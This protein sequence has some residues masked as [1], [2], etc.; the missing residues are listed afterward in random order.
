MKPLP[1]YRVTQQLVENPIK[2]VAAEVRRQLDTL[3]APPQGEVAI[4]VGSRGIDN[5]ALV[6]KTAGDWLRERGASPF[7]VP[8]MGSHNGA[9]AAGQRAMVESLGVTEAACGMPIRSSMEC[10]QVGEVDAGP[11]WMDRHAFQSAGVLALNRVKLHT[12]FSGPLQSGLVKMLVVGLG[13]IQSARVFHETP[14]GQMSASLAAMARPLLAT[15]KV[16]AGLALV[17][18]GA[19]H[20][21]EVHALAADQILAREP[22]LLDRCRHY[23]PRLPV[24]TLNVLVVES[25]G[26]TYSGTGMDPNVVG[27]RGP[28]GQADTQGTEV[29]TI[30]ALQLAEASQGNATGVGLADVVTQR[31]RDAIDNEKTLL[32]VLTTGSFDRGKA[33]VSLPDDQTLVA[34]LRDRFG[35]ARWMFIPNTLH[36]GVLWTTADVAQELR[37]HPRCQVASA[38]AD[39][40]FHAGRL[41]LD[42]VD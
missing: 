21:A 23:F 27:R 36:L 29:R 32:N 18:D 9:T 19:D 15:G 37:A 20:T 26:K 4:T 22:E 8:A 17:E 2:D 3:G 10:V 7:V 35:D 1:L 28:G 42:W 41:K 33:P 25:I 14:P 24:G 40:P 5:L 30:A 38:P 11:V 39:L 16:W 13:K 34:T 12:S 31:L 6:T